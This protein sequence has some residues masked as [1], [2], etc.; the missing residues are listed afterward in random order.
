MIPQSTAFYNNYF[1]ACVL[2]NNQLSDYT[3]NLFAAL[4]ITAQH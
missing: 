1:F 4:K 3:F 2:G